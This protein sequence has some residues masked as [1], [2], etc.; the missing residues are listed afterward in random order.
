M[1][2]NK[3]DYKKYEEKLQLLGV[4][5][6]HIIDRATRFRK[7]RKVLVHEKA[8]FDDGEII[9]AQKEADNAHELRVLLAEHF[10][11]RI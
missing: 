9:W 2:F 1:I 7:A 11:E 4:S 6:K 5:E 8:H 10:K 3:Y